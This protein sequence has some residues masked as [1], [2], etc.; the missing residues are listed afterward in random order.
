MDYTKSAVNLCN[1]KEIETLLYQ[2][3]S[4]VA[5]YDEVN[6]SIEKVIPAV[7]LEKRNLVEVEKDKLHEQIKLKI[8]ELGSYQDIDTGLYA[9]KQRKI[10][11]SYDAE[12]F[13]STYP[14]Y[15]KAV[16]IKAIDTT[17]LNGLIKGGL[18]TEPKLKEQSILK[19][20][21]SYSYIIK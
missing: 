3:Q 8:D 17:K 13:D 11:K 15:S 18:I 2:Y 14:E 12:K 19:E 10:S 1:P 5:E 4:K 9:V 7:L 6:E 16:I 20:T 21:E